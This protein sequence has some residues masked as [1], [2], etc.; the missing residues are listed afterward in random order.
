MRDEIR[1][2]A[3]GFDFSGYVIPEGSTPQTVAIEKS[4][5][6]VVYGIPNP[7]H[8]CDEMG[9]SSVEHVLFVRNFPC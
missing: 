4:G 3:K 6:I 1:V 5:N 9:C 2:D 7:E 8:N